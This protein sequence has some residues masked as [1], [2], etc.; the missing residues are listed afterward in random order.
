MKAALLL[1]IPTYIILTP[2]GREAKRHV[3]FFEKSGFVKWL[4]DSSRLVILSWQNFQKAEKAAEGRDRR[5]LVLVTGANEN[6]QKLNS[7]FD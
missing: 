2:G 6:L 1:A 4:Q 5:L 7:L 3:G